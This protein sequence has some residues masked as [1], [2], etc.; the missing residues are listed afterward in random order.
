MS[1]AAAAGNAFIGAVGIGIVSNQAFA[2]GATAVPMPIDEED[3]ETWLWHHYVNLVAPS[4][5]DFAPG[6]VNQR[7]EID[8]K[9]MRKVEQNETIYMAVQGVETGTIVAEVVANTRMLFKLS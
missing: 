9:A 6:A 7:I 2:I 4:T 5:T 3:S 8:S 1:A